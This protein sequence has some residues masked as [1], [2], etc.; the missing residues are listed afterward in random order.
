[1]TNYGNKNNDEQSQTTEVAGGSNE[2]PPLNPDEQKPKTAVAL[3]ASFTA[4]IFGTKYLSATTLANLIRGVKGLKKDQK[5]DPEGTEDS[6]IDALGLLAI[7][8]LAEAKSA[9][10]NCPQI[11]WE[12]VTKCRS[13]YKHKPDKLENVPFKP[14][15]FGLSVRYFGRSCD[16]MSE[17]RIQCPRES[18]GKTDYDHMKTC[19]K[20]VIV[21][22]PKLACSKIK[23]I[24][25]AMELSN[26]DVAGD[27]HHWQFS[28][29]RVPR[30]MFSATTSSISFV[31]LVYC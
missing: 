25:A 30:S 18:R 1:M 8:A 17:E 10:A 31:C 4:P 28:L 13:D 11:F 29:T 3:L 16:D 15:K 23:Q 20:V 26:Y 22:Q 9:F 7:Y 14:N 12:N 19:E 21:L 2:G 27:S 5:V 24:K 6:D